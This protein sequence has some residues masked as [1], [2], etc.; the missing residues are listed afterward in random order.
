MNPVD[1]YS[2]ESK[3]EEYGVPD[4]KYGAEKART[5]NNYAGVSFYGYRG[6]MPRTYLGT[7]LKNP[8]TEGREYC[9]K[10]H[11]SLADKSKYAAN[12]LAM[13]VTADSIVEPSEGNLSF[14][15]QIKSL[16]N[17]PFEQQFLWTPICGKY[18]AKGGEQFIIIGNFDTD[19]D[20]QL[21]TLRLSR[22][23]SGR[24]SYDA[25]YFIDDVS[26]IPIDVMT[27]DC[28]CDK[29]AGGGMEVEFKKFGAD[30]SEKAKATTKYLVNSDGS[31][32]EQSASSD[33]AAS[34]EE[35][36][37]YPESEEILFANTKFMPASS[38]AAKLDKLADYLKANDKVSLMIIGHADPSEEEVAFIG[39]RRAFNV[40]K[41]LMQRGIGKDRIPYESKETDEPKSSSDPA[42]N[43]RVSFKLM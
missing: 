23:F 42:M 1:L 37:A 5:G 34:Q 18:T 30:E 27:D 20:T 15:P 43:Q 12:N 22:E 14:T 13:L 32:V 40:Q 33:A 31:R 11:V 38:E 10:F 7:R 41:E 25:Y 19:E 6:R 8:L 16:T 36:K 28:L 35:S 39:K 29:I 17:K 21:E 2:T 9:L 24:Q 26:V 3:N 4:N